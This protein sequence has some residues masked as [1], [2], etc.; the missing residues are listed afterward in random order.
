[1]V[2]STRP[3]VL[4]APCRSN[5]DCGSSLLCWAENAAGPPGSIGGPARGYCTAACRSAADCSLFQQPG[6]CLHFSDPSFG[7]CLA[8]CES[9]AAG[10]CQGRSEL[11]CSTYAALSLTA[12][13][14]AAADSG[15]C[16]PH[17]SSDADCVRGGQCNLAEPIASCIGE[18]S[19]A[20]AADAGQ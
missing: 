6:D 2:P 14:G 17:C 10:V 8:A 19:D 11:V 12:P 9:G 13:S 3:N 20:G 7:V 5:A 15:L 1:V 16:A 18:S 4:G